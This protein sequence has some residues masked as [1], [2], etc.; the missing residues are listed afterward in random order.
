[1]ETG[2]EFFLVYT[3]PSRVDGHWRR[4]V[5][6]IEQQE[7]AFLVYD[8]DTHEEWSVLDVEIAR[9]D[10]KVEI[11]VSGDQLEKIVVPD[12]VMFEEMID[13]M[14]LDVSEM[15]AVPDYPSM[16]KLQLRNEFN[17]VKDKLADAGH[18]FVQHT[19]EEKDL[20]TQYDAILM[21]LRKRIT[22]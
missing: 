2:D 22:R 8:L 1:M 3:H 7:E 12:D 11:I 17:R 19:E 18:L 4:H 21:E 16:T 5:R 13:G 14:E 10:V 15:T 9:G 6:M 20:R